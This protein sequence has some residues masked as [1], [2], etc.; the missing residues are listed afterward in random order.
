[1]DIQVVNDNKN[2]YGEYLL[3]I[4]RFDQDKDQKT[5]IYAMKD[6]VE[7]YGIQENLVLIGEGST[8]EE[9]KKIG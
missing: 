7:N 1:M 2:T 3:M 5:V 8:L 4:G 9:C 6:L